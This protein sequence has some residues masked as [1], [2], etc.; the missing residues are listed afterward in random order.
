MKRMHVL[1]TLLLVAA[2]ASFGAQEMLAT[3][4]SASVRDLSSVPKGLTHQ[5]IL[6]WNLEGLLKQ[7]FGRESICTWYRDPRSRWNFNDVCAPLSDFQLYRYVFAHPHE[8]V[9][10]L[11]STYHRF[12]TFGNYP[13]PVLVR[14]RL[15]A[16]D[17]HDRLFLVA[18]ADARSL[19][20]D[21]LRGE[22]TN[23]QWP[24][25]RLER[26][27]QGA[28]S[29]SAPTIKVSGVSWALDWDYAC[30]SSVA[31]KSKGSL[32]IQLRNKEA[33]LAA[34]FGGTGRAFSGEQILTPLW[35]GR[36]H[37]RI[38]TTSPRGIKSAC[39]WDVWAILVTP[40]EEASREPF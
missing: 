27:G 9:L 21:C 36:W 24:E 13:G 28:G 14:G 11:T 17:N 3:S 29:T 6:L 10:H 39:R 20:L 26:A 33:H 30:R 40:A 4:S 23:Y 2:F 18:Y 16:C 32:H 1:T 12:R 31:S 5:G 19:T 34:T 22:F 7:S 35:S 8:S 37:V 25:V 15:I 38:R